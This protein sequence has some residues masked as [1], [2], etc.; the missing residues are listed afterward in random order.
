MLGIGVVFAMLLW[1]GFAVGAVFYVDSSSPK[2]SDTNPGTH[3][4]PFKTINR[5]AQLVQPGDIVIV[6]SG[7]YREHVRLTRSGKPGEPIVFVA[8]PPGSVV[9]TGADPI[10]GWERVS[11]SEPIYR[12][13]WK[14]RFIINR[15]PDGSL[16]E[17]HPD[18][19]KHRLWGRAEL[20]I[21]DGQV[22]LPSLTLEGLRTAWHRHEE[23]IKSGKPSPILQPPLPNL[24]GPFSGMF[25]VD[26][27]DESPQAQP[28]WLYLWLADGSDP[29]LHNVE[30]ATR[31]A[32]FGLSPWE[33]PKG[34]QF[35]HVR[36]FV[37][38]HAAT[39]PQRAAVWLHGKD[40]LLEDCIVEEMAGGGV[41][42]H[43][44]MRR[45]VI[46]RCGH[47]GGGAT[48][49]HFLNEDCT[50]EGNSWKPIER[51][52]DAGGFKIAKARDGIFRRC[53]FRQ[54]GGPGLWL[55]IHVRN[56]LITE[57]IFWENE[58][59]GL[60]V[61][62]SRDISIVNNLFVRNGVGIVGKVEWPDW[63][64]AGL[65]IAES[66]NCVVAFNTFVGN[67]DGIALREQGPRHL[68]TEDFGVIP[69][70][71]RGHIIVGNVCAFNLGYQL[72][73]W[74]D[75]GFFGWHP[76]ERE[77]F[78]TEANYELWLKSNPDKVFDPTKIGLV[79]DR[80]LYFATPNQK[81]IL[82]GAPWRPKF[83]EFANLDEWA[84]ATGF[85]RHS[86]VAD[87][88]FV[89]PREGNF[90]F[91]LDSPAWTK[92]VGWLSVPEKPVPE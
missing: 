36:G 22:C 6:K 92:Q 81:L 66:Q 61:E 37:F 31:S 68:E 52:W 41:L 26:P 82:Y 10:A 50:W 63:G 33:N 64:I 24:I 65:T 15:R 17:H 71:N 2:A 73:L 20:V 88:Q 78:K 23:A 34:V 32:L 75:N 1:S 16:V 69:Y 49:E 42:V 45:C 62:I 30:A 79:I 9:L 72:A 55:D 5:A 43:G 90:R 89:N 38:R 13:P 76:A 29:N 25:C 67:K 58:H 86:I 11:G 40:N 59:H 21:V 28:R 4:L 19:E 70:H 47:T 12:I 54:N 7:I 3:D 18:D 14:H 77:K 91:R 83:R 84:K 56:V 80:N 53:L 48:G 51:G 46:R 35:V 85:D 39:F 8:D 44:T 60:F 27:K 74:Y 57:C 87:P